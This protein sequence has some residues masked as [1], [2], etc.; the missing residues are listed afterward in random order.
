MI[1][2]RNTLLKIFGSTYIYMKY[3][4]SADVFW[5]HLSTL[6][7][8]LFRR[9]VS[10]VWASSNISCLTSTANTHRYK[11]E[12][13]V[14]IFPYIAVTVRLM[15]NG[16]IHK[17]NTLI[18]KKYLLMSGFSLGPKTFSYT[19]MI[20][21]NFWQWNWIT[22]FYTYTHYKSKNWGQYFFFWK[23]ASKE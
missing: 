19:H 8:V 4:S 1:F 15:S 17:T 3:V 23:K 12:Y 21:F 6:P 16:L 9:F 20:I 14:G 13:F 2:H 22:E 7:S 18:Q 10:F 5:T 11:F